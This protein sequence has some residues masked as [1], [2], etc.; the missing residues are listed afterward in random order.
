MENII[1]YVNRK[2]TPVDVQIE[3]W[4]GLYH[5]PPGDKIEISINVSSSVCRI[6]VE[7]QGDMVLLT[8]PDVE[9]YFIID[10]GKRYHMSEFRTNAEGW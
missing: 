3:P 7:D 4:A 5:L 8:L 1:E 10:G 2:E 9:E 6:E